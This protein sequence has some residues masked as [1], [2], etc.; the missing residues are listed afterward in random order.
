[1][2]T[3]I[4]F[5]LGRYLNLM[6][7]LRPSHCAAAGFRIFCYPIRIGL[8]PY[9]LK[10][11]NSARQRTLTHESLDIRVYEW[12][13]GP[14]KVLL[15]HGWQSHSFRW[16]NFVESF[17]PEEF[18][19]V[20]LDAPGHG[21][22][23]G[24]K[25]TVPLYSDVVEKLI[26]EEGAF[27]VIISHSLGSFTALYALYRTPTLP[28]GKLVLLA[29]PGEATEFLSFY[30][31]SLG[32]SAQTVSKIKTHFSS[33]IGK[34]VEFFSA[35]TFADQIA[36]PGLIIHDEDDKETSLANSVA[37]NRSWKNSRLVV[38]TGLGHNL[39]SQEVIDEVL[40]FVNEEHYALQQ[41]L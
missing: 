8:K 25:L 32:L 21:Q 6:A 37:I 39:K 16:K 7:V 30:Q 27:D 23:K 31:K 28:V 19:V 5:L 20:A 3:I 33:V 40:R 38:T 35:S 15:L 2:K 10:F 4:P 11:L 36:Q 18:T 14:R 29:P 1:M 9:Q 22:S 12:G 26:R 34:E 17:S 41:T 13:N 24:S